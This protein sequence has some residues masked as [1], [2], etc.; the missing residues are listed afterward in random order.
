MEYLFFWGEKESLGFLSNFYPSAFT[1]N[2]QPFNCSEQYFMKEKQELFDPSN[3]I[4]A[5]GIMN[6]TKPFNIKKYGRRVKN[7]DEKIWNT[8]KYKAMYDGVYAKF[9]Q[10]PELKAKLLATGEKILVE[11]SPYDKIW[12][13]GFKKSNALANKTLWGENLLGQVLME[14]RTNISIVT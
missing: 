3:Q 1:V 13:I 10:I 5:T 8:H 4:L 6:E 11:A 12:G 7:F 2:E 14:V 9:T